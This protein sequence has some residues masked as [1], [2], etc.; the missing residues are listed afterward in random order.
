MTVYEFCVTNWGKPEELV[1]APWTFAVDPSRGACSATVYYLSNK[2]WEIAT[3]I[4]FL[5][6]TQFAACADL[7]VTG[8]LVV[9]LRRA[10]ADFQRSNT[11][12]DHIIRNT[13]ENNGLSL[14]VALINA[15]L[16]ATL[17]TSWHVAAN[18]TLTK[19]YFN[20]L[21]VS[22]N[23]RATI[24]KDMEKLNYDQHHGAVSI[25]LTRRESRVEPVR[26]V[27]P[28]INV[29]MTKTVA[30]EHDCESDGD[31]THPFA[32]DVKRPLPRSAIADLS[33]AQ[34]IQ[35]A[36]RVPPPV[37]IKPTIGLGV[38]GASVGTENEDHKIEVT[39]PHE[40]TK[41]V[42][43]LLT[44]L[45]SRFDVM[46]LDVLARLSS[47]STRV[48]SLEASIAELMEGKAGGPLEAEEGPK[49]NG[50]LAAKV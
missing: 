9:F 37:E 45:E 40:L 21:L 14:V 32:A 44:D 2:H 20:S 30:V 25:N 23:S 29:T 15:V 27:Y 49:R 46:S 10:K 28:A 4:A 6:F 5:S 35:K 19:L 11:V 43:N 17:S 7:I 38:A 36:L 22:L 13:I 16:F 1:D 34:D 47:L 42:D 12:L 39:S 8:A 31:S 26:T 24:A 41:F 33:G 48:D 3:V 50:S 18:L